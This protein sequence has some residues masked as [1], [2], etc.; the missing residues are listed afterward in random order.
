MSDPTSI[1]DQFVRVKSKELH[2]VSMFALSLFPRMDSRLGKPRC[3]N[4]FYPVS[5]KTASM[6]YNV[7]KSS[8]NQVI[9][10]ELKTYSYSQDKY[11]M[12]P[13][14]RKIIAT[15]L[16]HFTLI[17]NELPHSEIVMDFTTAYNYFNI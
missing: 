8:N 16:R 7:L 4:I 5:P 17:E 11:K 2:K 14:E 3:N 6:I 1:H 12:D 9:V 13:M 15:S 10:D